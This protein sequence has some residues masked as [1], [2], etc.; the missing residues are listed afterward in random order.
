MVVAILTPNVCLHVVSSYLL[1]ICDL[2][3]WYC[4][5]ALTHDWWTPQQDN[6]DSNNQHQATH[7]LSAEVRRG[8]SRDYLGANLMF[9]P[10]VFC[11]CQRHFA[12][13][14]PVHISVLARPPYS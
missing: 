1:S 9:G 3:W 6:P 11:H 2:N 5:M 13:P 12:L 10:L 8:L 7:T 4:N 14:Q